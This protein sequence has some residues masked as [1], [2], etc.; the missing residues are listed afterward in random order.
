MQPK[1]CLPIIERRKTD[2]L[3]QIARNRSGY[4]WFEVWLDYVEGA[5]E[6]FV[7]EL[8]DK[9]PDQILLV[10]RRERLAPMQM[11]QT[12]RLKLLRALDGAAVVVDLDVASQQ[13][14]FDAIKAERLNVQTV[15]SYHN[16]DETP[17]DAEL[18]DIVTR[19]CEHQPAIVKIATACRSE[20]DALRLLQLQ[21]R[22]KAQGQ[23]HVVLGMGQ[24]GVIT[25]IFGALWGNEF[26]FAPNTAAEASAPGQLTRP[27]LDAIFEHLRA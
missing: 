7:S 19:I 21:L 24:P 1:Y 12:G 18:Q 16:Y 25:R 6:Q 11:S 13:A 17:A 2:V 14:E 26:T 27:Q 22:L 5:D 4:V 15:G 20:D 3:G 23:R 10:F 9:Y 8:A